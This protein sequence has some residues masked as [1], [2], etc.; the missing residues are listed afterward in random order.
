LECL[1]FTGHA[2][3]LRHHYGKELRPDANG[4]VGANGVF[5]EAPRLKGGLCQISFTPRGR[6]VRRR[7]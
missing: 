7:D 6:V 1:P 2:I 3:G 4:T 5:E